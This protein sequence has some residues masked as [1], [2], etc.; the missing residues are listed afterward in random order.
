M[1]PVTTNR[2][3]TI[4]I[5]AGAPIRSEQFG[6]ESIIHCNLTVDAVVV[7]GRWVYEINGRTYSVGIT[8]EDFRWA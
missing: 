4:E 2:T 8:S 5:I 6:V 1:A 3:R 7:N